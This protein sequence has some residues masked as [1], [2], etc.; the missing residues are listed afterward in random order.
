MKKGSKH[1]KDVKERI[2]ESMMGKKNA[3]KWPEDLVTEILNKMIEYLN[4]DYEVD[5][6]VQEELAAIRTEDGEDLG[7]KNVKTVVKKIKA[8]P[9]LKKKARLELGIYQG[10]WFAYI[11]EKYKDNE[12]IFNLLSAIDDICETNTYESASNG[13]T[14]ANMAKMNLAKHYDWKD[15]VETTPLESKTDPYK[16]MSTDDLRKRIEDLENKGGTK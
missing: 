3:E 2:K 16:D 5:V 14:N 7:T 11:A 9:H 1:K 13:V 8:R 15:K 6:L 4:T 10:K 12:T